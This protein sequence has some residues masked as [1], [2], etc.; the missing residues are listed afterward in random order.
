MDQFTV[1]TDLPEVNP[2][3]RNAYLL[4][5]SNTGKSFTN[6]PCSPIFRAHCSNPFPDEPGKSVVDCTWEITGAMPANH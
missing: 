1:K 4:L 6:L 3:N 2:F 5:V